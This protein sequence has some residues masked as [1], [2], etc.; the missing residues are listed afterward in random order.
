MLN[1][2]TYS[3]DKLKAAGFSS[4]LLLD[5][6]GLDFSKKYIQKKLTVLCKTN[7]KCALCKN[8][9]FRW[10]D[11]NLDHINPRSS[12][13]YGSVENL[14]ATHI[15]CNTLRGN[16]PMEECTPDMFEWA[17]DVPQTINWSKLSIPPT[18]LSDGLAK[19]YPKKRKKR[20][21]QAKA[22]IAV[23]KKQPA[24]K[25]AATPIPKKELPKLE[26]QS[27]K[28]PKWVKYKSWCVYADYWLG[29]KKEFLNKIIT[30]KQEQARYWQQAL[31]LFPECFEIREDQNGNFI[32]SWQLY[33]LAPG[34]TIWE[35]ELLHPEVVAHRR[36]K[37]KED[38]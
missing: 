13:G 37:L 23:K 17:I 6:Q 35:Y 4:T 2:I 38:N 21:L 36:F 26:L 11:F 30:P 22:A 25:V 20:H 14:Q 33:P 8:S 31:N 12:G 27:F 29:L 24:A 19:I 32:F 28:L 7:G 5:I 15:C 18:G 34:Q 3:V 1:T 9:I 16:L 10:D